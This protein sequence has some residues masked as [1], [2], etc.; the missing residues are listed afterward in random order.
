MI[1][2]EIEKCIGKTIKSIVSYDP[3]GYDRGFEIAFT[4]NTIIAIYPKV[5]TLFPNDPR[6]V[7]ESSSKIKVK[8]ATE[9]EDALSRIVLEFEGGTIIVEDDRGGVGDILVV[10]TPT[11]GD[12][13]QWFV[14]DLIREKNIVPPKKYDPATGKPYVPL[15]ALI[16][17]A[18]RKAIAIMR[19]SKPKLGD[20][21]T[22]FEEVI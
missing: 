7:V 8:E 2:E 21:I 6:V 19:G 22:N 13:L 9:M 10:W 4:D 17:E 1:Y 15:P 14:G 5:Y 18:T 11:E 3:F 20:Y 12:K 16:W